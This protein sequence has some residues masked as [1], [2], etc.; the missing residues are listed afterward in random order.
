MCINRIVGINKEAASTF[1]FINNLIAFFAWNSRTSPATA[2]HGAGSSTLSTYIV[3]TV[4][5]HIAVTYIAIEFLFHTIKAHA[6][7]ITTNIGFCSHQKA[8]RALIGTINIRKA[9]SHCTTGV[10]PVCYKSV[11]QQL[12]S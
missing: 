11:K 8:L 4:H 3:A 10:M 9:G 7:A 12:T 1:Y 2:H 6:V 5:Y